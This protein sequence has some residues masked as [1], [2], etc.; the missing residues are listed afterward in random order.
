MSIRLGDAY[1]VT[2][3]L[4]VISLAIVGGSAWHAANQVAKVTDYD[5]IGGVGH[6]DDSD[7]AVV[8]TRHPDSAL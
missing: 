7:D 1:P 5:I 3:V 4:P 2:Q 6:N 8:Q